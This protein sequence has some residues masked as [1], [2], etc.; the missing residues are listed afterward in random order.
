MLKKIAFTV[1]AVAFNVLLVSPLSYGQSVTTTSNARY[2]TI[3]ENEPRIVLDQKALKKMS[4][5]LCA[6]G[7]KSYFSNDKKNICAGQT[8]AP[9]I[10]Y[11]CMWDKKGEAAFAAT[12][13]G[14]CNLD[15]AE[16]RGSIVVSKSSY[17]SKPP[18]A[19]GTEVQCCFRAGKAPVREVVLR[20]NQVHFE[21]NQ[22]RILPQSYPVLNEIVSTIKSSDVQHVT[23]EGHT[24]SLGLDAYN[25]E[26]SN[27]RAASV[28]EYLSSHGISS[29]K[30]SSVGKGESQPIAENQING[31][32]NR[33]GRDLNRRVE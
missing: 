8:T 24:D 19:Y 1:L 22:S 33:S 29:D 27:Q 12:V 15:F 32:D 2:T 10:A 26:L 28:K 11:S 5:I 4:K 3:E 9:D 21:F 31:K 7:F 23:I 13:K 14:P 20:T 25:E 6:E 30:M 17:P 18:L 16:H